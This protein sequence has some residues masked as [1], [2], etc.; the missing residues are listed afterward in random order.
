MN[1][2]S[3]LLSREQRA[4]KANLPRKVGPRPVAGDFLRVSTELSEK[5]R[6]VQ[7]PWFRYACLVRA[8]AEGG[9]GCHPWAAGAVGEKAV[10]P[11]AG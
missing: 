6:M 4:A 2:A 8:T 7:A 11:A 5:L 10:F 1:D 3:A 9:V